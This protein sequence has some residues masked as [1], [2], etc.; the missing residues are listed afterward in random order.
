MLVI[1][2]AMIVVAVVMMIW[3][4]SDYG[5]S[6]DIVDEMVGAQFA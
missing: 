4:V 2:L 5:V 6:V 1:V 3:R